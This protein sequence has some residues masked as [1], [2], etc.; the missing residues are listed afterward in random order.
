MDRRE[1]LTGAAGVSAA[2]LLLGAD[3]ANAAHHETAATPSAEAMAELRNAVA[4]LEAKLQAGWRLGTEVE[5]AEGRRAILHHLH[6]GIEAWLHADPARPVF[7]RFVTPEKKMLGDN[8]DAIYFTTAIDPAGS[9]RIRGNLADATYTSF[10]V[11]IGSAGGANATSI[12]ATLNDTQ[13]EAA[14]DGS[15]E[16]IASP[17]EQPGNWLRLDPGAGSITTRHYY[18]RESSIALDRLHHVPIMIEPLADPGP[19][20]PPT[21][22]SIA[23]GIRR[24]T[25]FVTSTL[26]PPNPGLPL[27]WVSQVPNQFNPPVEENGNDAIGFAA[28]DNVYAMAPFVLK[29][30]EALVMTGRFP[31]CRFSNVVLWNRFIQTVDYTYRQTS[32]NRRQVAFEDDGSFRMVVAHTDP[33]V[34]NWL[35]TEGHTI[36][37]IFW[38]FQLPEEPLTAIE[39]EVVPVGSLA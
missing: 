1:F 20:D 10:A 16:V 19:A 11:E 26:N 27:A 13:F 18:E 14:A 30:D 15:Y 7:K 8:P 22:A 33:G 24:V 32:L 9:Y 28:V 23:E 34:P 5:V 4:E 35:D 36:G 25:N 6:H 38:R 12:G 29:P 21:D 39:T 2:A 17:T 3:S 31:K 37:T